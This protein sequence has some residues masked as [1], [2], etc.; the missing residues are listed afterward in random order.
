MLVEVLSARP[1]RRYI[2]RKTLIVFYL[3]YGQFFRVI[4]F[5]SFEA[6]VV[7]VTAYFHF[8]SET[9]KNNFQKYHE[10]FQLSQKTLS[11]IYA[12]H[13]S[14]HTIISVINRSY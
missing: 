6:V 4:I 3:N 14:L 8:E 1:A 11:V 7:T 5:I 9:P 13:C 2:F 12:N 10:T